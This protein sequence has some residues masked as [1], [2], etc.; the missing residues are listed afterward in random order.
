MEEITIEYGWKERAVHYFL[1]NKGKVYGYMGTFVAAAALL[2]AY[3]TAGPS[4]R[5]AVQAKALFEQWRKTPSDLKL[6]KEMQTAVKKIPGLERALEAETAQILLS[7]G[8]VETAA[9]MTT[10]CISRLKEESPTHA[11]FA[12]ISVQIEKQEYQ[13]A[14]EASVSLKERLNDQSALYGSNL[15]RIAFLQKQV[16]NPPGELAAWEEV[17]ALIEMKGSTNA[18][19]FLKANFGEKSFSLADFITQREKHIIR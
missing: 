9:S 7:D 17:R 2:I 11:E 5:E 10:S 15:V 3:T 1:L 8:Q 18:A 19:Q 14:L 12:S 4:S 6:Y 13:K 16:G